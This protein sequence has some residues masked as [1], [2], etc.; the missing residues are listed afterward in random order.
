MRKRD[1][2]AMLRLDCHHQPRAGPKLFTF[3]AR[4]RLG[5][6]AAKMQICTGKTHELRQKAAMTR[7]RHDEPKAGKNILLSRYLQGKAA[8]EI[9]MRECS[10]EVEVVFRQKPRH[11]DAAQLD[12]FTKQRNPKGNSYG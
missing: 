5:Q 6:S 12:F 9:A 11:V 10:L 2:I 1:E 4:D 8:R 7:K 3:G